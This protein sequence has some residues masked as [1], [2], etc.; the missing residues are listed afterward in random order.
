[1]RRASDSAHTMKHLALLLALALTLLA[2]PARARDEIS[3]DFFYESLSP[4]GEWSDVEGYGMVWHPSD[5]DE[6]WAPYTD[7]YWSYT[8][9][10]WTWV[11]YEDWGGICYHYGRWVQVDDYGWCWVPDYEWG[12]AWVSWR[13]NDR[14]VGWAPLP[15]E[16]RWRRETGFGVWVDTHFD[17]GPL[18]FRFCA[19]EDFGAPVLRHVFLPRARNIVFINETVNITNIS[20]RGDHGYAFNGGLDYDWIRPRCRNEV[21]ALKLVQNTT[22]IYIKGNKGNVFINAPRGNQLIVAA[23]RVAAKNY[24]VLSKKTTVARTISKPVINRGWKGMEKEGQRDRLVAK[25]REENKGLTPDTAPAH[26]VKP[27]Q[28]AVVPKKG[29]PNAKLPSLNKD[30]KPRAPIAQP[31]ADSN[32]KKDSTAQPV[33]AQPAIVKEPATENPLKPAA[34]PTDANGDGKPD[35]TRPGRPHAVPVA[36]NDDKK[37]NKKDET[38]QPVI[39]QPAIVKEP[40]TENPLKPVAKTADKNGDGKPD[41][42][43]PVRPNPVAAD[44]N[45]NGKPETPKHPV[46]NQ[47]PGERNGDGV[48]DRAKRA[49]G[50]R[51]GDGIPDRTKPAVVAEPEVKPQPESKPHRL[52]APRENRNDENKQAEAAQQRE[53][54]IAKRQAE[55][56]AN[57]REQQRAAQQKHAAEAA[58]RQR[59]ME[60]SKQQQAEEKKR[61]Q[62]AENENARRALDNQRQ[63]QAE[64]ARERAAESQRA[65][66]EN[67]RREANENRQ[68]AGEAQRQQQ[69]EAARSR[70]AESQRAA[71]ENARRDANENRQR[72]MEAQRQQQA[73]TARSRAAEAAQQRAAENARRQPQPERIQPR[74]QPQTQ[75]QSQPQQPSGNPGDGRKKKKDKDDNN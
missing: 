11:S 21:P 58:E 39:A 25:M 13:K 23:P 51:N 26:K 46:A 73:E 68:R 10:G 50:D 42:N 7:G 55:A 47:I 44:E 6:D 70:A 56:A 61:R 62:S 38:P 3:F 19:V 4:Y 57:E 69:A 15:P 20:Y 34:K 30:R 66:Q 5:M 49:A 54:A 60:E 37:H 2:A 74:T 53:A 27:T 16:A 8:D 28:L 65:A 32:D 40:A 52:I 1:M 75:P 24:N 63:Q 33:I 14:H 35:K 45:G 41:R 22:N 59:M 67:A 29:D 48:A 9:A 43:R 71:Q 12:P 17:I 18:S 64:A 72:A 36:E 31:V